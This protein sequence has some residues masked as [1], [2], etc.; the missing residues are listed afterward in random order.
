MIGRT[1][2]HYK[3]LEKL[4]EGGMGV[5]YK[6]E[7]AK[8]K[9][10]VAIKFLPG[11]ISSN[12]EERRR[13]EI[14]AQAAASLN[15]PNIAHIYAI[16]ETEDD[17]FIVMELINGIELKDKIRSG[18]LK[19]NEILNI[20]NQIVDGLEEAHNKGIVHRDVKSANI[21]ITENGKVKIMD[22]GLAKIGMGAMVTRVGSTLG[23]V[24]YMSPEQTRGENV[25]QRSDIWSFGV[26]LYEMLTGEFPFKGD[27]D[28]AV[29]YSILNEDPA[30]IQSLIGKNYQKIVNKALAKNPD[31]RYR[32][33]DEIRDELN[34]FDFSVSSKSQVIEEIK[35]IAVLPFSNI[36]DDATTN[37]LGFALADQIIGAMAY[38]KSML[39]RPS[40]SIRKYQN[41]FVD[42]KAA[43]EELKVNYILAGNFLKEADTIRLNVELID[44]ASDDMIWREPIEI[45]YKNVFELQDIVSQKV[46]EGLRVQ[47]SDEE[48]ERMKPETPHS[49]MAYEFYLR[50]IAY[51]YNM[52][53]TKKA[54]EKLEDAVKLDPEYAPAYLE[55]GAR[56]NQ[57]SQ[58][59]TSTL[60]AQQKAE[61]AFL[62]ALS[63]NENLLPALAN[64]GIQ[65][66]D[67]GKHLKA[68]EM[69]IRALKINRTSAD[70]HFALS[71]HYRYTGF[72]EESKKEADIALSIDSGNPRFRSSIITDMFLGNFDQI[73]SSFDLDSDSPFTLNYLGE[74]A[75]RKGELEL[76]KNYFEKVLSF[77]DE[78]GEF[79][80]ASS[81][82]EFMKGNTDKAAEFNL[83]RELEN[84]ADSEIFYEIARVYGLLNK[85][86]DCRR[87]LRKSI[88]LGYVSYPS[89]LKDSFLDPVRED[90]G[91]RSLLEKV[92]SMHEELKSKLSTSY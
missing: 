61:G 22:F 34:S 2:L 19:E 69:L 3:I 33:I 41:E 6:A 45:K 75:F 51:P 57:L 53:G 8:L 71:Y 89:M 42:L 59:G 32:S 17:M 4:G 24:A 86:D 15:H 66:T 83:Q 91:I 29:V 26:L 21:M 43:G 67:M 11:H 46:V 85:K 63:I 92:K 37:F 81:L 7:D 78:I 18:T 31:D 14:E 16:E 47:F 38:S 73:L 28:Q 87:A 88:E 1:V 68:N 90:P 60:S 40:S 56:Y 36:S 55:L 65:Y 27:Y 70:L 76:A 49:Q 35:K 44:L 77:E 54:I 72:L 84:P 5:V 9:R 58:V 64:L 62:K 10:E 80:F 20:I 50:A 39:V 74:V 13:F 23:T 82:M 48:R 30:D 25:D 12:R 79:Y 52:D